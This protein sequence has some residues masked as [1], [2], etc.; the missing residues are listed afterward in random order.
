MVS[1][2]RDASVG[3]PTGDQSA[4]PG[5]DDAEQTGVPRLEID[6]ERSA[7]RVPQEI[8]DRTGTGG[9]DHLPVGSEM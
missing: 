7:E 5:G 6:D 3:G 2:R 9:P 1:S 8:R 4:G